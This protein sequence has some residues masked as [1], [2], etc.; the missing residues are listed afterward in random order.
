VHQAQRLLIVIHHLAIDGVSWRIVLED[1]QTGYE[2]L[3]RGETPQ[4]PR[5]TTSYKYWAHRLTEYAPS[6]A[7]RDAVSYWHTTAHTRV[8]PLPVDHPA[9]RDANTEASSR[10]VSVALSEAETRALLYEVPEAYRT[11]INDVLLTALVQALAPWTGGRSLRVDLE[12]HGREALFDEVDLSR[13]VGWFTSIFPVLLDLEG[14]ASPGDALQAIK[15]QLRAIPNRG[16][17]YGVLRYLRGDPVVAEQ[18]RA[19]PQA[20]VSF[21]YLGQFDQLLPEGASFAPARESRGPVHSPWGTRRHLLD[22]LGSITGGQLHLV[23]TYSAQVHQ[24]AIIERLAEGYVEAL[25]ALIA[26]CQSPAAGGYTP[27]DFPLAQLDQDELERV[28][29]EVEFEEE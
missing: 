7:L 19:L 8:V 15:E 22:V 16:I 24:R 17:G 5:K 9:G 14:A 3:R 12:G 13:T 23:W 21:N 4:L 26:H 11:Q 20:E 2:Q 28:F 18:L 1:L 6:A 29:E 27:S 10:T 25:R